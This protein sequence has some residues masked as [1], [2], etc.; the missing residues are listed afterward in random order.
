MTHKPSPKLIPPI[1]ILITLII[2][3]L[4]VRCLAT[5]TNLLN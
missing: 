3:A 1:T 5:N 2:V 4:L